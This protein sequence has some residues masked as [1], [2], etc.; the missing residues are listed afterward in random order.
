MANERTVT[1]E[2]AKFWA[3]K[4]GMKYIETSSKTSTNVDILFITIAKEIEE[5]ENAPESSSEV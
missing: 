4:R 3:N 1:I 5:K 2:E